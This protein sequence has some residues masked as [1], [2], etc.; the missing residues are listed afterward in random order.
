MKS[1]QQNISNIRSS[2][3]INNNINLQ[4]KCY[5]VEDVVEMIKSGDVCLSVETIKG[6]NGAKYVRTPDHEEFRDYEGFHTMFFLEDEQ[7]S[8]PTVS[9]DGVDW[10]LFSAILKMLNLYEAEND[11][12]GYCS[13]IP[14]QYKRLFT[15]R[16]HGYRRT[17]VRVEALEE[18]GI[19]MNKKV[20][21]KKKVNL[22][23]SGITTFR[24]NLPHLRQN[25]LRIMN[26]LK[27]IDDKIFMGEVYR[28][29]SQLE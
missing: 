12:S 5:S 10:Y 15:F 11:I 8:I 21:I 17:Y 14:S 23:V 27:E 6:I 13:L 3:I 26:E 29:L 22:Y 9:I 1:N 24:I 20:I 25:T 28:L 18:F 4:D 7:H 16:G 19:T 2:R